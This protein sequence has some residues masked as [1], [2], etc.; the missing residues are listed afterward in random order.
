[1]VWTEP[2]Y[3]QSITL[4]WMAVVTFSKYPPIEE[5]L[6]NLTRG[7]HAFLPS[8]E[9]Y[10]YNIK[11]E[12]RDF[13]GSSKEKRNMNIFKSSLNTPSQERKDLNRG[14]PPNSPRYRPKS[15]LK[16]VVAG[17]RPRVSQLAVT[18]SDY[19]SVSEPEET[20]L[21]ST[22][23]PKSGLWKKVSRNIEEEKKKNDVSFF[24][25]SSALKDRYVVT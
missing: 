19:D 18:V 11:E 14:R 3:H 16:S 13:S 20:P 9:K 10:C 1:M 8:T 6:A 25:L 15:K 7:N 24:S 23:K 21:Q 5:K 12:L 2:E 17:S 4:R 22:D